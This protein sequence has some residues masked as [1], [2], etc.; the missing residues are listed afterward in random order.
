MNWTLL[1]KKSLIILATISSLASASVK[2]SEDSLHYDN[3]STDNLSNKGSHYS[4]SLGF[5]T[6]S[7]F[8]KDQN[9]GTAAT[10][11]KASLQS[12]WNQK[13][14]H[15]KA[16]LSIYSFVNNNPE[17]GAESKELYVS[18]QRGMMGNHQFTLGRKIVNWSKVDETWNNVMSFWSPRFTWD[19]MYP[20]TVGMTGAFY[21]FQTSRFEFTAFGSPIAIPERGTATEEKNGQIVSSNPFWKPLPS[22]I[23]I[24]GLEEPAQVQYSLMMPNLQQLI[25]RPNFALK[26]KYKFQSGAWLSANTAILPVH[27][28]QL[29]AE[30]Y[31]DSSRG[32]LQVNIRPQLPMRNLNTVE[33]GFN[34]SQNDWKLWFSASYEQPF[35]FENNPFWLNP[36]ITPAVI[37][38]SGVQ[39][40]ITSNFWVH[41]NFLYIKEEPFLRAS[42][43]PDVNV[44]LPSRF[45]LKQG[46]LMGGDWNISDRVLLKANWIQDLIE[47]SHFVGTDLT[48]TIPH[49]GV[50]LGGGADFVI[51]QTNTGWVGQY[52]GQDRV[53]GWFKY[54]F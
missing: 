35:R 36:I 3:S 16:E 24:A 41:G 1:S 39:V 51:S 5:D 8:Y 28:V 53:R 18:T 11:F 52:Y 23:K 7:F 12:E 43:L 46:I 19:P 6:S 27:M 10:T 13:Y 22:S 2:A 47:K 15:E 33:A 29:A 54:V 30:P 26:A 49:S 44:S 25:M 20:E 9:R 37:A 38:S 48:Y 40:E 42:S 45:P 17:V 34:G 32:L 50:A 31:M 21:E 14:A 4:G